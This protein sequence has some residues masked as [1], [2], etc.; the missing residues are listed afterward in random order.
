MKSFF[1]HYLM[2]VVVGVVVI[3]S[4]AGAFWYITS[5]HPPSFTG[6]TASRGNVISSI[7]EAGTVLAEDNVALS[8]QSAGQIAHV[9]VSEGSVIGAGTVLADLDTASLS[10][11]LDQA[12]AALAAANAKLDELQA[13]TRPQQLDID[14]TAVT[15]AQSS[16]LVDA[17]N[18]YAAADD[19]VHN[20]TDNLFTNPRTNSPNFLVPVTD[21]QTL[22]NIGTG[23]IGIEAVL[24][25]WYA[26]QNGSSTAGSVSVP[27]LTAIADTALGKVQSYLDLLALAVNDATPASSASAATLAGYKANVATARTE[28]GAAV[29]ALTSAESAL[30]S[31]QDALTLAQA[32]STPQDIE[33]FEQAV[34]AQAQASVAS[35]QVALNNASLIAPF[36]G[37]IQNL[38]AQVGQVVSPGAPVLSLVNNSGLK[39]QAYASE[40]DVAKIKTGDTAQVTLDAFGTGTV[41]PATVTAVASAETQING[42]PS[43]LVTLHFTS[44]EPQI[45]DGMTGN[46]DIILAEHD[47]VVE[48]PSRLVINNGN[49]YFV[50]VQNGDR[51][52]RSKAGDYRPH[53]RQRDDGNHLGNKRRGYA[54]RISNNLLIQ[55]HSMDT[56]RNIMFS[57][58]GSLFVIGV[59]KAAAYFY[60]FGKN[61]LYR[62]V[63]RP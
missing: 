24:D 50:L 42:T 33:D 46:V 27:T 2:P 10:A 37:T 36:P 5:S 28:V 56:R 29:T 43:Y 47:T 38:T 31:A 16:V 34:V 57:V 26:A 58:L 20:Q 15:D 54:S 40:A 32:G 45:R 18:A 61:S 59:I 9:Y 22:N 55:I 30:A 19:A 39:I 11:N 7:D 63:C 3:I 23:R 53:G 48:V 12:N 25:G 4:A 14:Q 41:F 52:L 44:A 6:V 60:V 17:T 21:S 8:F 49:D 51:K 62:P 1:S 35:A 13:G